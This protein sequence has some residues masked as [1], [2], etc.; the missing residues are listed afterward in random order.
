MSTAQS[1]VQASQAAGSGESRRARSRWGLNYATINSPMDG[2]GSSA[3]R[4]GRDRG[5]GRPEQRGHRA[6]HRFGHEQ[7]ERKWKWMK[8]PF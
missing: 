8:P 3:H 5:H 6:D 2:V 4:G 7:V 1:S